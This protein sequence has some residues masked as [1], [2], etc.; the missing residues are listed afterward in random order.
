M[1]AWLVAASSL[2]S[3][4]VRRE[5][6]SV[7]NGVGPSKS[8]AFTQSHK[9]ALLAAYRAVFRKGQGGSV[10]E[11]S[12]GGLLGG[13]VSYRQLVEGHRTGFEPVLLAAAVPAR[14][15][16]WVLEAGTGAGAGI[17]CLAARVAG[18]RAVGLERD[19]ALAALA[20]ENFAS[21]GFADCFA[22]RGDAERPPFGPVF[23]HVMANPPWFD[24]RG[25][26]PPEARRALAHMAAPGL[27]AAWMKGLV[28][29]L[30]PRGRITLILPAASL[31]AAAAGL[32][33]VRCGGI[34]V[35]P[36]WPRAGVAAKTIIISAVLGSRALDS[37]HPGLVLHDAA[38]ISPEAEA[39]L[40][41]GA[42]LV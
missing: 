41:D 25:T 1:I 31:A 11:T 40:R 3:I 30:R 6:A 18:V 22:V 38:G 35:W 17:L 16:D 2:S 12:S 14:A 32:R 24:A 9:I 15:G 28:G 29:C 20:D 19:G 34:A 8:F 10:G 21:N 4:A 36:L 33:A 13:R 39:I 27:L 23:H 26:P 37:L 5:S 7:A 42:A